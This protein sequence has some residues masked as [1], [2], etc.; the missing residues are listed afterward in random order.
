MTHPERV[1]IDAFMEDARKAVRLLRE[2]GWPVETHIE[3]DA[4]TLGYTVMLRFELPL[5]PIPREARDI[6]EVQPLK[7]DV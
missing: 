4:A 3:H 1:L 5:L 7:R 6:V 2:Q